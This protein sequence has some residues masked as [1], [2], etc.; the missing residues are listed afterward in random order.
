MKF[1]S[2]LVLAS[3][4]FAYPTIPQEETKRQLGGVGSTANEFKTGGCKDIIFVWA[5]GSTE[6]GN[7]GTV[8]G[9]PVANDLK[10][11]FPGK[12]AVQGVDYGARLDTNFLPGGADLAGINEMK[13]ILSDIASKCPTSIVVT[14]GYS[15]GAAVNHRAIENAPDAQKTQIAGV[16]TFGDTQFRADNGQIPNFPKDKIKIICA[17]NPRD[18]V[19]DGNLSAAVL[20][21]HLS[22]GLYA[23]E[24]ANFLIAQ[25]KKVQA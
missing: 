24:G 6:I 13:S 16:V 20:A 25:I 17:A 7:M 11:A 12:V 23:E 22:Y 14:G 18:T 21:P 19:C 10:A 4:A 5:R 15:Q 8:V 3:T 1:F 9:P 2:T